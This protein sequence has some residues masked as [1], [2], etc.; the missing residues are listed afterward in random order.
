M[1]GTAAPARGFRWLPSLFTALALA[2]CSGAQTSAPA[3]ATAAP[4]APVAAPK[5]PATHVDEVASPQASPAAAAAFSGTFDGTL[6][7]GAPIS[8]TGSTAK[9]GGLTRD[10][11]DV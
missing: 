5:P 8:L 4:T 1:R 6:V 7:F 3:P 10:G 11:Y 9:E 2:A